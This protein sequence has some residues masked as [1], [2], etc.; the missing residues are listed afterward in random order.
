MGDVVSTNRG[1]LC[2]KL[3]GSSES[4]GAALRSLSTVVLV[5]S[6][7]LNMMGLASKEWEAGDISEGK[8][9]AVCVSLLTET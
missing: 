5:A 1:R 8:P 4:L 7:F 9:G 2:D 6:G 3:A